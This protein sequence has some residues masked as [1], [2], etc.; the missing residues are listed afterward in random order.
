[1][2][3]TRR[4]MRSKSANSLSQRDVTTPSQAPQRRR[5]RD[6]TGAAYVSSRLI[7]SRH[8][9]DHKREDA[10]AKAIVV[11]KSAARKGVRVRL[12]AIPKPCHPERSIAKRCGVEGRFYRLFVASDVTFCLGRPAAQWPGSR[13]RLPL[14]IFGLIT[15]RWGGS[16]NANSSTAFHRHPSSRSC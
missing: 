11:R 5:C 15:G 8:S 1:V 6:W 12:P 16:Q 4:G 7:R 10:V 14:R 3:E 13:V 2:R 9:P